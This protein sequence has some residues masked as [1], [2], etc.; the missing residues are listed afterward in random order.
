MTTALVPYERHPLTIIDAGT[1]RGGRGLLPHVAQLQRESDVIDVELIGVDPVPG[2]ANRFIT[3]AAQF[4]LHGQAREAKIEDVINEGVP[5]GAPVI[6]NMDTPAAHA[7]ALYQL[8]DRKI[9]VLGAL[10]A[11]SPVDGQL[12]GFRYV[13][14][15]EEHEEKREVAGMFRS[16]HAFAARGG[17]E[18]VWG[19][20]GRPE[21]LPLEPVYRDWTGRF[22]RENLAK[23]AIGLSSNNH[24]IEMTRDGRRT[25]PIIIRESPNG[26]ASPF[27]LATEVLGNPPAPILRGDDF[28]IAELG[29]NGARFHFARLGKT[30]GRLRVNG[31]AGFDRDTLDAAEREARAQQVQHTQSLQRADRERQQREVAEAVR[32]A[33]QKTITRRRPLFF[34]D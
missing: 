28:A 9:P 10:Y 5:E 22:V 2:R 12:H 21:H 18:R 16:L 26:W 6:L 1:N 13:F 25:L 7:H 14:G 15:A 17:R 4:G 29:H 20:Q 24:Y 31:Y 32:R 33:E 19:E 27:A 34:T 30:D 3:D 23:T 8:A 11:A